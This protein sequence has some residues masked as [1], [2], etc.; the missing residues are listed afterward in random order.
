MLRPTG[1]LPGQGDSRRILIVDD[2]S[3]SREILQKFVKSYGHTSESVASGAQA[4][5]RIDAG[6]DLVLLDARMPGMGGFELI[7]RI[8]QRTDLA[9]LPIIMVTS[10]NEEAD[11]IRA[12]EA[13]ADDFVVKPV[14]SV[15]L[16][17]RV[18]AL[19]QLKSARDMV[20]LQVLDK[21]DESREIGRNLYQKLH[22]AQLELEAVN[23]R[24]NELYDLKSTFIALVSHELRTPVAL[25]N[26]FLEVAVDEI[27][28]TLAP[29]RAEFLHTALYN[30]KRLTRI[31]QELT[32]FANLQTG[33]RIQ[34]DDPV[35][36]Q[37]VVT[38]VYKSLEPA[39]EHK[40]LIAT[41]ELPKD[42]GDLKYDG[43]SLVVIL[44]NLLSNAAKFTPEGGRIW[45][46]ARCH[47][48]NIE[49]DINDSA[50]PIPDEKR[51]EIFEDFRQV[52]NHLTRRY[53]GMGLGL[54]VARRTARALGG[55]IVLKARMERGNT[56]SL[57][58]PVKQ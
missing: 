6:F 19:L 40:P 17:A 39:L 28:P 3:I 53:E 11:R 38:Q 51:N 4:I 45:L 46:D 31:V 10:L 25:V 49:I 16:R 7:Q 12:L 15:A 34:L 8:R 2:E 56:F 41:L 5:A 47:N 18:R 24:L 13:G 1:S 57:I 30:T 26:G 20:R 55:D 33:I 32:D 36:I 58:L 48:G 29:D 37:E 22:R 14:D 23:N 54:A 50:E 9:D 35:P 21:L 52:E 42:I 44:R 27:G 43:E